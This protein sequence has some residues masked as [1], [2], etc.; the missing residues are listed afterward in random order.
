MAQFLNDILIDGKG[1]F[2]ESAQATQFIATDGIDS[3]ELRKDGVTF[4]RTT[5][6]LRPFENGNKNLYIGATAKGVLDWNN[7]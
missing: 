6:Y 4:N 3:A 1:T 7:V 2:T 5:S